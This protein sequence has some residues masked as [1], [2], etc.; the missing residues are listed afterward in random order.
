MATAL[1]LLVAPRA[2]VRGMSRHRQKPVSEA[3][4]RYAHLRALIDIRLAELIGALDRHETNRSNWQRPG[5]LA[6]VDRKLREALSTFEGREACDAEMFTRYRRLRA[7]VAGRRRARGK[8]RPTQRELRQGRLCDEV[9]P[10]TF[11]ELMRELQRFAS[12]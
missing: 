3:Q 12:P 8:Q 11:R 6:T 7:A 9:D 1:L 2:S 4:T 5:A 10:I